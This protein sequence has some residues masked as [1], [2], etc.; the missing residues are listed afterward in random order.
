MQTVI[1]TVFLMGVA[2]FLAAGAAA[3]ADDMACSCTG[4][5]CGNNAIGGDRGDIFTGVSSAEAKSFF[6]TTDNTGWTCVV[7]AKIRG[8]GGPKGCYCRNYCGNGGI[9]AD[10]RFFDL[11]LSQETIN[12]DYG[13]GSSGNR[14]GWLCGNYRGDFVAPSNMACVCTGSACGNDA[15][16]GD[17]GDI[18]I[19]LSASQVADSFKTNPNTGWTCMVPA[20]VRGRGGPKSC[21]CENYCGNGGIGADPRF[22]DLGL[23]EDTVS[24]LYGGGKPGNRTGW[25]CGNFRGSM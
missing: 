18:F 12:E 3:H 1:R 14:T 19:N 20:K 5:A 16:G 7:P 9:G 25:L 4:L 15:I 8:T 23:S 2:L 21:Y 6:T 22:I 24:K 11:G 17:Q 10:P 13:G